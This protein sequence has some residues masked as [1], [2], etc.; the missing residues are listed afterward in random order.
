MDPAPGVSKNAE[1]EN[2]FMNVPTI[3]LSFL[4]IILR[5]LNP[6]KGVGRGGVKSVTTG[7]CE[8]QG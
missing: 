8:K 7:D 1:T 4:G 6:L 5:L 3:T 2:E